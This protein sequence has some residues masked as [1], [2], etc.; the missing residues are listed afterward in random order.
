M[1][2]TT[3]VEAT[4]AIP[5]RGILELTA[6][7]ERNDVALDLSGKT[8]TATARREDDPDTVLD[9][10]LEDHVVTLVDGPTG[11]VLL[12]LINAELAALPAPTI[13]SQ[14]FDHLV[15]FKVV[16]D[17]YFPYPYRLSVY[18]VFD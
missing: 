8:V 16:E 6:F 14:T 3:I 9:A 12:T 15:F 13:R 18:K 1:P 7:I 11:E 17:D 2:N 10:S 4:V 5:N